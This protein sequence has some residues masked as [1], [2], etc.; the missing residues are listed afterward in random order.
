LD[1][2]GLTDLGSYSFDSSFSSSESDI[3]LF[4]GGT[5]WEIKL[6]YVIL[7]PTNWDYDCRKM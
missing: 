6:N 5:Y 1:F 4:K 7:L 2:C 3:S